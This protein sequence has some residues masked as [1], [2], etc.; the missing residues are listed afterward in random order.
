[1]LFKHKGIADF[2]QFYSFSLYKIV[3]FHNMG[4]IVHTSN[5]FKHN[6][7]VHVT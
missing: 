4:F 5:Y 3:C 7:K 6:K 2:V 1:M